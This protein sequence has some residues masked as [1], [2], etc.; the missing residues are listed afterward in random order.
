M[1]CEDFLRCVYVVMDTVASFKSPDMT[2]RC[3]NETST[4]GWA[5]R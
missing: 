3:I 4:E 1:S 5:F 2:I